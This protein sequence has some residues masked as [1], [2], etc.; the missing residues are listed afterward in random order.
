[1]L[2]L[3]DFLLVGDDLSF[4]WMDAWKSNPEL[5]SLWLKAS[6]TFVGDH[7]G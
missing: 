7:F 4:G 2:A 3:V 5:G 1:M 6:T